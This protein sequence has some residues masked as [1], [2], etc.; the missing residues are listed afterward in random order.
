MPNYWTWTKF[1]VIYIY[2]TTIK[3]LSYIWYETLWL[4]TLLWGMTQQRQFFIKVTSLVL[5]MISE[6]NLGVWANDIL[7]ATIKI[8]I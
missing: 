5:S 8:T 2:I 4:D 6:L 3:I 7:S 1:S